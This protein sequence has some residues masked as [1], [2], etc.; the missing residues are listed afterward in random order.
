[1]ERDR[2]RVYQSVAEAVDRLLRGREPNMELRARTGA[3][4]VEITP[5]ATAPAI[6]ARNAVAHPLSR[7][8][9]LKI[10][11][12]AISLE[13]LERAIEET[14]APAQL[15][16]DVPLADL[17]LTLKSQ[18]K[19]NPKKLQDA[20]ARGVPIDVIRSNTLSQMC[21]YLREQF[22]EIDRAD[23]K[24]EAI[25][26]AEKAI[27]AALQQNRPIKLEPRAA[28]I[29]RLQHQLAVRNGLASESKG[30]EPHRRVI[31]YP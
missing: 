5:V 3:G 29:R 17:I 1:V 9:P 22:P 24:D 18:A 10:F 27:A 20:C 23:E 8:T 31:I 30:R 21:A 13:K 14:G 12:Y 2:L 4:L 26:E 15:A 6:S 7:K 28:H 25:A 11:P 19:G 16:D